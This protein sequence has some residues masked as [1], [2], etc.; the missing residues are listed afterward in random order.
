MDPM[1]AFLELVP[2]SLGMPYV[3]AKGSTSGTPMYTTSWLRACNLR[4]SAV[5]G[6][7]CPATGMPT[8]PIFILLSSAA[9]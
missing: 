2:M 5:I 8:K 4:A 1:H 3:Q 7:R 9:S 6:F